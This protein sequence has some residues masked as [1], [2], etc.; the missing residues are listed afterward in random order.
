MRSGLFTVGAGRRGGRF[1]VPHCP[2]GS[3]RGGQARAQ[4]VLPLSSPIDPSPQTS[5]PGG[6]HWTVHRSPQPTGVWGSEQ[7]TVMTG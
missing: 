4:A 1:P 2:G 7:G 6:H 3:P 5:C